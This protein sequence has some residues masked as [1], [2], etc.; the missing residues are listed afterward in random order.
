[1]VVSA[2]ADLEGREVCLYGAYLA[3]VA[4]ASAGSG[5]HHKICHV[6]GGSFGLPHAETH[7]IVLPHVLAHNA[8]AVPELSR[9]LA[10]A[11]GNP[12]ATD[13]ARAAVTAVQALRHRLDAPEALRDHGLA[14]ADLPEAA[15]RCLAAVPDSNPVPLTRRSMTALLRAAWAGDPPA[16]SPAHPSPTQRR[17]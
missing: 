2:P 5:M 7:A 14:E 10:E 3:A 8:P 4:F 13:P 17:D 1:M 11:L 9:R 12:D 16:P 15:S 6:L